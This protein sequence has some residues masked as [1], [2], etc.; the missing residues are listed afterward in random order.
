MYWAT[1]SASLLYNAAFLVAYVGAALGAFLLAREITGSGAA[2]VIAAAA[3]AFAPYRVAQLSHLQVLSVGW[4][5]VA[6]VA[7][8]RHCAI[9]LLAV[10]AELSS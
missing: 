9:Q 2:A 5:P 7:L 1:H 8:A 3:F 10:F 6:L 4:M